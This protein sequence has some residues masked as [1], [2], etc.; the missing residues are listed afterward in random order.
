MRVEIDRFPTG[1]NHR[2]IEVS[3]RGL[4]PREEVSNLSNG[5][6]PALNKAL[7]EGRNPI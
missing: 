5:K 1:Y 4:H 2:Y 6:G 7:E 3:L